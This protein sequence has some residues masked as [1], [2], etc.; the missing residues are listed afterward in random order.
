MNLLCN[1]DG[2]VFD[3]DEVAEEVGS[4]VWVC[5]ANEWR[6]IAILLDRSTRASGTVTGRKSNTAASDDNMDDRLSLS[7]LQL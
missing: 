6:S 1:D 3:D 4:C 5:A 2:C 7:C